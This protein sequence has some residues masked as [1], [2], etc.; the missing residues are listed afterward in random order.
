[1]NTTIRKMTNAG[2][3][4]RDLL[5]FYGVLKYYSTDPDIAYGTIRNTLS[6]SAYDPKA[7][8]IANYRYL[9]AKFLDLFDIDVLMNSQD[10]AVIV[11]LDVEFDEKNPQI[12]AFIQALRG[13]QDYPIF[14]DD[15]LSE[16]EREYEDQ[17]LKDAVDG[18][19]NSLD[20]DSQISEAIIQA[21]T[22][23]TSAELDARLHPRLWDG[24]IDQR[25][26]DAMNRWESYLMDHMRAIM[27][28]HRIDFDEDHTS[29]DGKKLAKLSPLYRL[30]QKYVSALHVVQY[31]IEDR[32]LL[33]FPLDSDFVCYVQDEARQALLEN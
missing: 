20:I 10:G 1:M 27:R 26:I 31:E 2:D 8:D 30:G 15:F 23:E 3:F 33:G 21:T 18:F 24:K 13:L 25:K 5:D 17:A 6:D 19:E 11:A 28:E 16:V 9:K 29:V 22:G 14:S 7:L 12:L 4:D 32:R